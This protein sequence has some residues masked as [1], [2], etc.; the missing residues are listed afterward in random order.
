MGLRGVVVELFGFR[1]D[2]LWVLKELL[3]L[4]VDEGDV[5]AGVLGFGRFVVAATAVKSHTGMLTNTFFGLFL[6]LFH[7][8]IWIWNAERMRRIRT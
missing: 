8:Q 7:N 6:D 3:Q 5:P 1:P 4:A 2:G